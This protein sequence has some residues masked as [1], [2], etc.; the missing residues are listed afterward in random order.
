MNTLL[1]IEHNNGVDQLQKNKLSHLTDSIQLFINCMKN[2]RRFNIFP[3][4]I[5]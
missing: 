5:L 4:K 2:N 3:T 1:S